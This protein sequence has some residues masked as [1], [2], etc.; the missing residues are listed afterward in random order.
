MLTAKHIAPSIAKLL[1]VRLFL[2]DFDNHKRWLWFKK[3]MSAQILR[4]LTKL[5]KEKYPLCLKLQLYSGF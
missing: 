1:L 4:P 2:D 3:G 5:T